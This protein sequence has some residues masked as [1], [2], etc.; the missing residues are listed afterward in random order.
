MAALEGRSHRIA[1]SHKEA[2]ILVRLVTG[3]TA[4]VVYSTQIQMN[5]EVV[6]ETGILI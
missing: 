5:Q 1:G 6:W 3:V 4:I 2:C